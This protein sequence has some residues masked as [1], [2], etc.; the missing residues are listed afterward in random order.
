MKSDLNFQNADWIVFVSIQ[1]ENQIPHTSASNWLGENSSIILIRSLFFFFQ[2]PD[3]DQCQCTNHA[4]KPDTP[5]LKLLIRSQ[6]FSETQ[7]EINVD[8]PFTPKNQAP[9]FNS[10]TIQC[11]K[12]KQNSADLKSNWLPYYTDLVFGPGEIDCEQFHGLERRGRGRIDLV[13]DKLQKQWKG[14]QKM[15]IKGEEISR[16]EIWVM[17]GFS[18]FE[19]MGEDIDT[20]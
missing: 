18:C 9:H 2:N 11:Q 15:Q 4:Q 1:P 10:N 12:I 3:M 14:A 5:S 13:D 16:I 20:W 7:I 6:F 8:V 19:K 17:L